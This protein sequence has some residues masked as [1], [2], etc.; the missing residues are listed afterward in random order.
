MAKAKTAEAPVAPEVTPEVVEEVI[1]EVSEVTEQT[2]EEVFAP[3]DVIALEP[4]VV[5]TVAA[6]AP[7]QNWTRT[8]H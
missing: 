7:V 4:A 6:E 1:G 8:D 5:T 3:A 2:T